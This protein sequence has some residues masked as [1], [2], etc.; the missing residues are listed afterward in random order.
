MEKT[1]VIKWNDEAIENAIKEVVKIAKINSM[2]THSLMKKITGNEA[3]SNAVSK[4]GGSKYWADKLGLEIKSCES[5]IG[6]EYE[7]ECMSTLT[8]M[9]YDCELTKS[10]YPYDILANGNIKIDVKVSNLYKSN[11]GN[12]YTFNLEKSMPTCD[13]FVC[14]CINDNKDINT[15]VIPSC[16]L[17]GKTQLSVGA[18]KSKYDKYINA[19]N[20]ISKYDD[21]Y[22]SV[23]S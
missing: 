23:A 20:I 16:V 8:T 12:F 18:E 11:R 2:P 1:Q 7:C 13:I 19:W 6:Y 22:K 15:F 3:L 21:F 9:G 4:H 14:Y 17:S 10:R 5:K